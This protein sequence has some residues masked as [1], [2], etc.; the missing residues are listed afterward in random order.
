MEEFGYLLDSA[1][2]TSK[3]RAGVSMG[4]KTALAIPAWYSGVYYLSTSVAGLPWSTFR[5]QLNGDRAR[6]SDPPWLRKP[7]VEMPWASLLEFWMMSL[8]HRGNGYA[9]KLRN[10]VGQV[11]G[12]RALHPDRVKVGQTAEGMKVFQIDG[13]TDMGFTSREV[14]HIPGLSYDG[15]MGLDPIRLQAESLAT[16]SAAEQFAGR[17]FGNGT[18]LQAYIS[19]PQSLKPEEAEKLA[20]QWR[21]FHQGVQNANDFGVLGNGAEYKTISLNPEQT[22][23]LETRKFG[24]VVV[25]QLLRLPPHKLYD[26]DRATFSNIEHQA[27]EAG[28][29]GVKPWV[30]RIE[31][32][33]NFHP[34]LLATTSYIEAD[35]DGMYRG[36]IKT[37]FEAKAIAMQW[38]AYTPR[39]WRQDEGWEPMDGT[40]YTLRPM[41]FVQVG[42]DAQNVEET[43]QEVPQ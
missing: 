34:D 3:T 41:N 2:T 36:D 43:P 35:L 38:G 25:A 23:L 42:P 32:W 17:S 19:L 20:A 40:D 14:V 21:R 26:L 10:D 37:R 13:R 12:L 28:T 5:R 31:T 33:L 30:E 7:D 18:H 15:L 1:G 22:Q 9:F 24:T 11:T 27:I 39:Q 16:I 6:R 8:L 4:A 29:D